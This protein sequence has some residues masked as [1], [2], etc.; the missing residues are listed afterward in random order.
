MVN[1]RIVCLSSRKRQMNISEILGS[2]GL[3]KSIASAVTL[4]GLDPTSAHISDVVSAYLEN[5]QTPPVKLI[6]GLIQ[7]NQKQ[8]PNDSYIAKTAEASLP[9]II[10]IGIA[11]YFIFRKV[12]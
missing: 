8:Y 4:A 5:G 9:W 10:G 6:G 7:A 3:T 11:V 2:L 1:D 12:F